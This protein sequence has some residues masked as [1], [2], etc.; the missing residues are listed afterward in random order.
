MSPTG[1]RSSRLDQALWLVV[2]LALVPAAVLG[3]RRVAAEGSREQVAVVMD[4]QA[5][6]VQGSMVGLTSLELGRRYQALGLPGVALYEDT[7]ETLASKGYAATLLGSE[8]KAQLVAAGEAPP[9]IPSNATLVT[10]L[11]PGA[12]DRLIAKNVPPARSFELNGR[13]WYLW[14]GSVKPTLPAGPDEAQVRLWK[15]AGFDVAYRPR[16]GPYSL[17]GVGAD[18]P[19]EASY[20]VHAGTQVAGWPFGLDELVAASQGFY[21]AVIEGSP[22]NGMAEIANKVPTVR[23]LSFNQ[24]YV[25]RRLRPGDLVEKYLLGVEERNVRLLYL[26]PYTTVELGDPIANTEKL[27]SALIPALRAHGYDVGPLES[28]GTTYRTNA[29]LRGLAALGVLAGALL[30]ARR[31]P[32]PWG[33]VALGLVLL[34]CLFFAGAR[35]DALALLAALVFPALGYLTFKERLPAILGAT[36]VS[37]AGALLLAAVGSERETLLA[38]RPFSGVGLTLLA[39]PLIFLAAY[40]LRLH[41]PVVWIKRL[42]TTNLTFGHVALGLVALA[43][44]GLVL[45][46]RGNDPVIG[47]SQF[48]LTLRSLLGE[49]VARP[50]FKELLGH[51][52]ALVALALPGW[53]V[54]LRAPLLTAGVVAQA[55]ILNSFSHYHTPLLISLERTGVALLVGLVIGAVLAPLAALLTRLVRRWL[56]GAEDDLSHA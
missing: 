26:R 1:F 41:R 46:R 42:L 36:A 4:E 13:T 8:L 12:L 21:T 32:S 31:F 6:A 39:P 53:P 47:V 51:P 37:L 14:P 52:A 44:V 34:A 33:A 29:W 27:V 54:W 30:L 19:P 43:A 48:E 35:W 56:Q 45:L 28:L 15:S 40:L 18:F 55:S 9:P 25:D 20:I 11:A 49:F 24:D 5:L 10:A 22:Q 17:V 16:N 2:L 3:L 50:R 23:L 38:I 7:I